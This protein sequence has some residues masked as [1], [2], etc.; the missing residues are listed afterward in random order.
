MIDEAHDEIDN[1]LFPYLF[2]WGF[3]HEVIGVDKGID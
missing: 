2:F 1:K 3:A